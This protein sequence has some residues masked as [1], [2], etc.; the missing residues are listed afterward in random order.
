MSHWSTLH[1]SA[2]TLPGIAQW[3][4][5]KVPVPESGPSPGLSPAQPSRRTGHRVPCIGDKPPELT[6]PYNPRLV[7]SAVQFNSSVSAMPAITPFATPVLPGA[8]TAGYT[9]LLC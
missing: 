3:L 8:G 2:L 6:F 1:T 4:G 7:G 9:L 5:H